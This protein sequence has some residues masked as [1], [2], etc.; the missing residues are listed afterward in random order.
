MARTPILAY[1]IEYHSECMRWRQVGYLAKSHVNYM[2]EAEMSPLRNIGNFHADVP[3]NMGCWRCN[4]TYMFGQVNLSLVLTLGPG[5][6]ILSEGDEKSSL[7]PAYKEVH[8]SLPHDQ[9]KSVTQ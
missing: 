7:T 3:D 2:G 6:I 5:R 4:Q 1:G 8:A 9:L